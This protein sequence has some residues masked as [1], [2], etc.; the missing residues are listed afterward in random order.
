MQTIL[1]TNL[2]IAII[3]IVSSNNFVS[4]NILD[5]TVKGLEKSA[6]EIA[7]KV[8]ENGICLLDSNCDNNFFSINNYCCAPTCCNIVKYITRNK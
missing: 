5:D 3:F 7:N 4:G 8:T 2:A 6:N 1:I